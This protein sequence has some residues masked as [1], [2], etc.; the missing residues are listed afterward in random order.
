[1]GEA[2][3]FAN[4]VVRGVCRQARRSIIARCAQFIFAA[5]LPLVANAAPVQRPEGVG[6]L[7]DLQSGAKTGAI[8]KKE[9]IGSYRAVLPP[10]LADLV[11]QGEFQFEAALK[12]RSTELFGASLIA[13]GQ[14]PVID[15]QGALDPAPV[16][17]TGALFG[18]EAD[19]SV[20]DTKGAA[21]QVLWNSTVHQWRLRSF[22][23][24]VSL[25]AFTAGGDEGRRV[26]VAVSRIY[27]PALGHSPGTLKPM[28]REKIT[29]VSPKSLSNFSWLTLRFLGGVED[30]VWTASP[31][32]GQVH[33]VTGSNRSDA[34]FSGAFS[35]DDLFVWSGKVEGVE[36]TRLSLS[37]LL[38]PVVE[39]SSVVQPLNDGTCSVTDYSK[40]SPVDLNLSSRRFPD[41]P[42]W[43]P[44]SPRMVLR[45]VWRI[46]MVSRD[47]F[48][49]EPRQTLY[50]DAETFVPVYRAVWEQDGRLKKF[51]IGIL[52]NV[53]TKEGNGLGWRGE[54]IVNPL[55]NTR[56]VLTMQ[57]LET[58]SK[59]LPGRALIDFDPSTLGARVD[60]GAQAKVK[61]TPTPIVEAEPVDE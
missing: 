4:E 42:G 58:C 57:K 21:Y 6:P 19:P 33:Q 14:A 10:E 59:M 3:G 8:V 51:V 30:Y 16:M 48:S 15:S 53:V 50:V 17:V 44:T 27:P 46:E 2:S 40:T 55:V 5:S 56:A 32:N 37:P 12:P 22:A 1:M 35:A 39:G 20:S 13:E 7:P 49:K 41:M 36:P 52:G 25:Y 31:V 29:M 61:A 34:L 38:V 54:V 23:S 45:N 26:D 24:H 47:P 28:F 11:A 18:I 60:K 9:H 43:V